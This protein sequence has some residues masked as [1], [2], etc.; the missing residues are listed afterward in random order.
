MEQVVR[1][2]ERQLVLLII[3][4]ANAPKV[5]AYLRALLIPDELY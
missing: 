4:R 1:V 3:A 5:V 2:T